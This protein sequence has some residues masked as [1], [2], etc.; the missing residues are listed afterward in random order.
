MEAVIEI[1]FNGFMWVAMQ[2]AGYLTWVVQTILALPPLQAVGFGFVFLFVPLFMV[3]FTMY[4]IE[5]M[6]GANEDE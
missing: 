4:V 1:L 5:M 6:V 3:R 2:I